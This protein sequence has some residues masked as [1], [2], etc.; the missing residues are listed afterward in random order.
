MYMRR[1]AVPNGPLPE[2]EEESVLE[3]LRSQHPAG[4]SQLYACF[5]DRVFQ[6]SR[7]ILAS[8]EDAKDAMLE[9]FVTV[10]HKWPTFGERSKFSSWIYRIAHNEACMLRRK[11]RRDD[12][13]LSLDA[14]V[15]GR[16]ADHAD[17][18]TVGEQLSQNEA[19]PDAILEQG[20][21]RGHLHRA[22]ASLEPKYRQVY[23]LKEVDG[24][25]LKEVAQR[26]HL[27]ETTVKTRVHRARL[28]LRQKLEPVLHG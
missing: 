22:I 7:R 16:D 20:E 3:L 26:T 5:A 24:L 13:M 25:S 11:R 27:P 12:A 14:A 6:L 8:E 2:V 23:C 4:P 18:P 10:L 21:L 15:D 17:L 28:Q 19:T 9:T 1:V